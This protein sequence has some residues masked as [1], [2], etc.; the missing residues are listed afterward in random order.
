MAVDQDSGPRGEVRYRLAASEDEEP[1]FSVDALSGQLKVLRDLD[2]ETLKQISVGIV[3]EDQAPRECLFAA[4]N[5]SRG[6]QKRTLTKT[7]NLEPIE[8]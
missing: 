8:I 1:W 4:P 7:K 6:T 3:A 2:Y 5:V